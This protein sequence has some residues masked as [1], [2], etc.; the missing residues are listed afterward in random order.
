MKRFVALVSLLALSFCGACGSEPRPGSP[1]D[2]VPTP[3]PA[4]SSPGATPCVPPTDNTAPT[5]TELFDRYFA[6]GKPGHC[7]TAHCHDDPGH[8]VWLCGDTA[9]SCYQG[10]V[11]IGLIDPSNPKASLIGNPTQST[12]SWVNPTGSMPFDATGPFPEGR[13]AVLAWVAA[14]AQNN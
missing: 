2:P 13:D 3:D 7:A 4:P 10:M 9:E 5:Y 12:L 1:S 6:P 11:E 8:N 14:C